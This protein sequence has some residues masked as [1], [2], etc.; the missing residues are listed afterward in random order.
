MAASCHLQ[1]RNLLYES[2]ANR[3]QGVLRPG[4]EP[5]YSRA[6]HQSGK[7]PRT[8][9]QGEPDWRETQDNL[10]GRVGVSR[11]LL[12]SIYKEKTFIKDSEK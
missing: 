11:R 3:L 2:R 6:V 10:Q 9:S 1:S 12:R 8:R 4:V 7:L 5:V